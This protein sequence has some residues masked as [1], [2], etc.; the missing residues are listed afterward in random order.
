MLSYSLLIQYEVCVYVC[1]CVCVCVCVFECVYP[2]YVYKCVHLCV[3]LSKCVYMSVN[4]C[5]ADSMTRLQTKFMVH[6]NIFC[7]D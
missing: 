7:F 2:R 4:M 6:E 5:D 3:C 1:V